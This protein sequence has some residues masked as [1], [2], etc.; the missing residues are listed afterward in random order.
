MQERRCS[1]GTFYP[2]IPPQYLSSVVEISK[3][4]VGLLL[5]SRPARRASQS[6]EVH[7]RVC[8]YAT[9][10]HSY[11]LP[12]LVRHATLKASQI[13]ISNMSDQ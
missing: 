10:I 13:L 6:C 2:R 12:A 9:C 1:R 4:I 5:V 7:A 3:L 11:I 8:A